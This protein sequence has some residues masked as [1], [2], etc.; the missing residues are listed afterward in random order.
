MRE[1]GNGICGGRGGKDL[2]LEVEK[3]G[4]GED[5][6]TLRGQGPSGPVLQRLGTL[7]YPEVQD[8]SGGFPRDCDSEWKS[9]TQS[10][11]SF[12]L[13]SDPSFTILSPLSPLSPK[14][15]RYQRRT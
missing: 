15:K 5:N 1:G 14:I 6:C 10:T 2:H 8:Q 9:D 11:H 7:G 3:R 4:E 13:K 12:S